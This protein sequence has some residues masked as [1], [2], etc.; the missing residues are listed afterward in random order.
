MEAFSIPFR[1]GF[2][3]SRSRMLMEP[4]FLES[5]LAEDD[6]CRCFAEDAAE[7]LNVPELSVV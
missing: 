7:G 6:P 3:I 1:V 4:K 2:K 5:F